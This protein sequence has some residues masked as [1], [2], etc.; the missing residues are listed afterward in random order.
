MGNGARHYSSGCYYITSMEDNIS[1]DGYT[2]TCK[3]IKNIGN[4][5]TTVVDVSY[6]VSY[7]YNDGKETDIKLHTITKYS[8]GSE[9]TTY[10]PVSYDDYVWYKS[11][12]YND[13][14]YLRQR[15]ASM[16]AERLGVKER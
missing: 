9:I 13:Q 2:Q 15:P 8:N 10:T 3:L 7:S 11:D 16:L 4:L 6:K 5:E 1:A 12:W 14:G